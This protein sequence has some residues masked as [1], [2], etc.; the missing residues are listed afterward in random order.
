MTKLSAGLI[1]TGS[2]AQKTHA[3][4]LAAHPD[5][6]LNGVWGRSS[7]AAGRLA[8]SYGATAYSGDD[9]L[10]ELIESSDVI[11]FAVPPDVQAGIAVQAALA[12]R[13]LL[14]EKPV[15]TSV[16]A[17]REVADAVART[18]V[19]SIVFT[20]LRFTEE[21]ATWIGEQTAKGGWFTAQGLTL[22]P[23]AGIPGISTLTPWREESGALWDLGPHVL[24]VYLPLLGD[25]RAVKAVRTGHDLTHLIMTH[26]S[27][28]SSSATLSLQAP[29]ASMANQMELLGEHGI[30]AMPQG[31]WNDPVAS[32]HN[33]VDALVT[34]VRTNTPHECDVRFGLRM[35]EILAE[36]E[37]DI[38]SAGA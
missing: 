23:A 6:D 38:H 10:T 26:D 21:T 8:G 33:A 2:W 11:A 30:A 34:S 28:A 9:G 5:I 22:F 24:S 36:L 20:T 13:H 15:A 19:S 17:A 12:G 31:G 3:P 14:L 29:P 27:G 4:A 7:D 25:V 35:T 37:R 1:G 32:Y 16:A 18:G